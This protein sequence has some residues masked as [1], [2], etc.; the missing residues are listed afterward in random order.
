MLEEIKY[1]AALS[2]A[3][4]FVSGKSRLI[5]SAKRELSKIKLFCI[6]DINK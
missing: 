4:L 3:A 1:K 2:L 6:L 5:T